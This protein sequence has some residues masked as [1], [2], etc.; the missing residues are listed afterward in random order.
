MPSPGS[1][2][3]GRTYKDDIGAYGRPEA[4]K[5][6]YVF[7]LVGSNPR[8]S[9]VAAA[10]NALAG[11]GLGTRVWI[12]SSGAG[13]GLDDLTGDH[14]QMSYREQLAQSIFTLCPGDSNMRSDETHCVWEALEAHSIPVVLASPSWKVLG[15]S[16]EEWRHPLPMVAS[17]ASAG[18]I[19]SALEELSQSNNIY[20]I[21]R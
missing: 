17:W 1:E 4:D 7:S 2:R 14:N 20:H 18:S 15:H 8:S 21:T 12:Q 19:L 16:D 13:G 9:E 5:R 6:T 3:W 10:R 11:I